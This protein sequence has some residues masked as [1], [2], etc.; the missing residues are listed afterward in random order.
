MSRRCGT[1]VSVI[2]LGAAEGPW[3]VRAATNQRTNIG[4]DGGFVYS[5]AVDPQN[6]G[7]VYAGTG[8]GIFKSQDGG[9]SWRNSGLMGYH[10]VRSIG[11]DPQDSNTVYA[12]AGQP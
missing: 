4:P 12:L 2:V 6:S 11:I 9:A 8:A 10:P 5:L 1:L 7:T 3:A